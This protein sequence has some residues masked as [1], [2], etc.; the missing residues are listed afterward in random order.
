MNFKGIVVAILLIA[1]LGVGL[2]AW[3][4]M[5]KP[6]PITNPTSGNSSVLYPLYGDA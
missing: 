1:A 4:T 6:T 3:L 5:S 2:Y